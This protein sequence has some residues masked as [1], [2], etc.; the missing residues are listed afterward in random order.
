MRVLFGDLF[1]NKYFSAAI[2]LISGGDSLD[3]QIV[4][5]DPYQECAGVPLP[6]LG[7]KHYG[8]RAIILEDKFLYVL[9]GKES[10][11]TVLGK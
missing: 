2:A 9:G 1:L 8:H 4:Q 5:Q 3:S 10:T 11:S 6:P 7:E